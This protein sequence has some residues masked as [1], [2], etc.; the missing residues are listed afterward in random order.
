METWEFLRKSY[1]TNVYFMDTYNFIE[2]IFIREYFR[3]TPKSVLNSTVI[4]MALKTN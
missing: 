2:Y 4:K 1:T 3:D